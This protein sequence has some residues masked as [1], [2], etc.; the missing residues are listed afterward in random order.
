[1]KM[2]SIE[3]M[4]DAG[5]FIQPIDWGDGGRSRIVSL[6]EMEQAFPAVARLPMSIRILLEG[7]VRHFDGEHTTCAHLSNLLAWHNGVRDEI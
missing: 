7:M 1:M 2:T 5:A 3:A 6:R 4:M